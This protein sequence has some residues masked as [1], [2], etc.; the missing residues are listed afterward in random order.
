MKKLLIALFLLLC[1]TVQ[2]EEK[3]PCPSNTQFLAKY[4]CGDDY[5]VF[6]EGSD[7]VALVGDCREVVWTSSMEI[8]SVMAKA[9]Q[10]CS[11]EAGGYTGTVVA[12]VHDLSHLSFCKEKPTAIGLATFGSHSVTNRVLYTL[13]GFL[14]ALIVC[15]VWFVRRTR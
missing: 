3:C 10:D 4:E 8:V 11:Q 2:A 6:A 7:V 5:W 9:G 14:V 12:G 1:V 15:V 13:L